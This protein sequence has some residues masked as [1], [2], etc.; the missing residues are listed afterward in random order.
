MYC[1]TVHC[2]HNWYSLTHKKSTQEHN[3]VRISQ[4]F[5]SLE[6]DGQSGPSSAFTAWWVGSSSS[7]NLI[8]YPEYFRVPGMD[9]EII[10]KLKAVSIT[11][12]LHPSIGH[13]KFCNLRMSFPDR[14]ECLLILYYFPKHPSLIFLYCVSSE[15]TPCTMKSQNH[16]QEVSH[17]YL[18]HTYLFQFISVMQWPKCN[19]I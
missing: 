13:T 1:M 8:S 17:I 9:V 19:S 15:Q 12:E 4:Y 3:N 14:N 2:L 11:R 10:I 7:V 5:Y 18:T 6:H 16:V